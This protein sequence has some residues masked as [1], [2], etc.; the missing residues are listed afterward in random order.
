MPQEVKYRTDWHPQ[1]FRDL[2]PAHAFGGESQSFAVMFC[3]SL[4][5]SEL[6]T[7]LLCFGEPRVDTIPDHLAFKFRN[8]FHYAYAVFHSPGYR[9][10]YA[11][12]LKIDFP[13]LPFTGNLEL[14]RAL[15]HLG[16]ELTALHLLESPTLARPITE[17]I[18]GRNSEVERVWWS[19]IW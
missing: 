19:K 7:L 17:F 13:R 1:G 5:P 11:E 14:F 3:N 8:I 9:S 4:G 15:A 6:H 16:G 18:G 12:F 2:P 10:R